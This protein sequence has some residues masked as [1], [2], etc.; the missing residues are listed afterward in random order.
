MSDTHL[1]SGTADSGSVSGPSV[2]SDDIGALFGPETEESPAAEASSA[3]APETTAPPPAD[4]TVP[5]A[6]SAPEPGAGSPGPI[7]FDR[8][9][10]ALENLRTEKQRELDTLKQRFA[11]AEHVTPQQAAEAFRLWQYVQQNPEEAISV[12]Q[13]HRQQAAGPPPPDLRAEDGTAVYSAPQM[14]KLLDYQQQLLLQQFESKLS[15]V[16]Q[17]YE[18]I[19]QAEQRQQATTEATSIVTTARTNWPEFKSLEPGIKARMVSDPTLTLESAYIAEFSQR[20]RPLME[21]QLRSQQTAAL[22]SKTAANTT[23]P[24]VPPTTP[25]DLKGL[26]GRDLTAHIFDQMSK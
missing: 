12:I 19:R 22:Q 11:W 1:P 24:G 5:P 4:A 25:Q 15:P 17:Q 6:V 16:Q 13:A 23:R 21:E 9:K 2:T 26:N 10:A 8:H 18:A 20:G 7:P 3:A 14:Q